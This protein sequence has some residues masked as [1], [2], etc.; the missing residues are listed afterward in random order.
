MQRTYSNPDPYMIEQLHIHIV[1]IMIMIYFI[2]SEIYNNYKFTGILRP[3]IT[4]KFVAVSIIF[5]SSG[6][7]LRSEVKFNIIDFIFFKIAI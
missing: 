6:I 7:S 5:F 2:S 4:V 1:I 3:E